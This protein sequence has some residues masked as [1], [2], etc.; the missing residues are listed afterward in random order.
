MSLKFTEE[1]H[2][3]ES[4]DGENIDWIS[5]T[6][7]I[8]T[9]KEKFDSDAVAIKCDK[10][11]KS[12][13]YGVGAEKIKDIWKKEALRATT[14]GTYYHNQ[15]ESDIL[16]F[17]T[18]TINGTQVP[19]VKPI[20]QGTTKFAPEQKLKE[21]VYPEHFVYLK[22]AGIC[23]QADYV[24]VVDGFINLLDYKTNKE[25]K[26]NSFV[27]WE[28]KSKMMLS[29][30]SHLEDCSYQH[31]CL[32]MS[33]YMFIMLKHNPKLKPGKITLRHAVFC[34]EGEDEYGYPIIMTTKDGE[35]I[36]DKVID[37]DAPYLK[38]D[39]ITMIAH[40][41]NNRK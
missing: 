1:G 3:Y 4:T 30:M 25:I 20:T 2:K 31:Y 35:P 40:I 12:K 16:S 24:D 5:T 26:M 36:V 29:P 23:G 34:K 6:S 9:F 8:A 27:N 28:N 10:N 19:V 32:Q 15:R 7:I 37:Y 17:N 18:M 11:K 13:W 41:K 14:M 38:K 21:G 33:I 39:V 22:S